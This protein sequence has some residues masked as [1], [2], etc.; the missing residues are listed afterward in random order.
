MYSL[1]GL[2]HVLRSVHS[3][4]RLGA[5]FISNAPDGWP[6]RW[7]LLNNWEKTGH[8][9]CECFFLNSDFI[10]VDR[11]QYF[12]ARQSWGKICKTKR[13]RIRLQRQGCDNFWD[14]VEHMGLTKHRYDLEMKWNEHDQAKVRQEHEPWKTSRIHEHQANE[15]TSYLKTRLIFCFI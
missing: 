11:Y 9:K 2:L 5:W 6:V 8:N 14:R 3:L 12:K 13:S 10:L 4:N 15:E 1:A 7:A